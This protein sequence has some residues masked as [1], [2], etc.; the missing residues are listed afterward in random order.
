MRRTPSADVLKELSDSRY[1]V[2]DVLPA[3]FHHEDALVTLGARLYL[4]DM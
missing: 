1:T 3:F 2:Y 4:L